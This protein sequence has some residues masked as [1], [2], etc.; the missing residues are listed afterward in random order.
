MRQ[1]HSAQFPSLFELANQAKDFGIESL[2]KRLINRN[3]KGVRFQKVPD[4]LRNISVER[5]C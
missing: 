3:I 4:A 5:T 2:A 1:L